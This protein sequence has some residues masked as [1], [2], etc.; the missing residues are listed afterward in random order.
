MT[1]ADLVCYLILFLF[2]LG[3]SNLVPISIQSTHHLCTGPSSVTFQFADTSPRLIPTPAKLTLS[4][5]EGG[6][7]GVGGQG[8]SDGDAWNV[9]KELLTVEEFDYSFCT[10][11]ADKEPEN[12][13]TLQAQLERQIAQLNESLEIPLSIYN[14]QVKLPVE[15]R[16][17]LWCMSWLDPP[18]T[19]V[20]TSPATSRGSSRLSHRS[21]THQSITPSI[22]NEP[23]IREPREWVDVRSIPF[24]IESDKTTTR[25][26]SP[27]NSFHH[28]QVSS[29]TTGEKKKSQRRKS[30]QKKTIELFAADA[31]VSEI[32]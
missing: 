20:V 28:L 13:L 3:F 14:T 10:Q 22:P 18:I 4:R 32:A 8:G 12:H 16:Q 30:Q 6:W 9:G 26:H 27:E 7:G 29:G 1:F 31:I 21:S 19:S 25:S 2:C 17:Q 24:G 23:I 15:Q 5:E 11:E